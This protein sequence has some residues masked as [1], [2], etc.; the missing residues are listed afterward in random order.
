MKKLAPILLSS[1]LI[2]A[3]CEDSPPEGPALE[4]T[5]VAAPAFENHDPSVAYVGREA[6][7]DCHLAIYNSYA[8]TGMGRS[9]RPLNAETTVGE[10]EGS[11]EFS[12][13]GMTYRVF[14]RDGKY[15]MQEFVKRS[16]NAQL[17]ME[18][19]ELIWV[20][21]SNNHNRA[22][23]I[24]RDGK[25]FQA[26]A[27][28]YPQGD[29]W[30][31]CPGY[32][33]AN[34]HFTRETTQSC[35]FCHNGV[36][37]AVEGRRNIFERPYPH[38]IGCERCHGPGEKHVE[39]WN[40][41]E[42]FGKRDD[43]TIVNPALLPGPERQEVCF[44]CHLGDANQTER[45]IRHDRPMTSFRPG[46]R[47]SDIFVPFRFAVQTEFDFGLSSQADRMMLSACYTESGGRLECLT[48]HD[49]HVPVVEQPEGYVA[50]ACQTCHDVQDC[51]EEHGMREAAGNDCV[52]CHMRR[53]EPDDQRFTEFT[54]HWIRRDISIDTP[55]HRESVEIE[56]IFP[57][58]YATL[59]TG[60]QAY[61]RA[62]ALTQM[63]DSS[64]LRKRAEMN[65]EASKLYAGAIERGYDTADSRYY[66]GKL[67]LTERSFEEAAEQFEAVLRH[68]PD[69]R[70]AL[71][72]LGQYHQANGD[73][74]RAV[75]MFDRIL[76][77]APDTAMAL[78]ERGRVL[79][80]SGDAVAA[81]EHYREALSQEPWNVTYHVNVGMS[82]AANGRMHEAA[83]LAR[84]AARLDPDRPDVWEFNANVLREIGDEQGA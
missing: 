68:D 28:W 63:T 18:E 10:F 53:A 72:A 45:I 4:P 84:S 59:T 58:R 5:A 66:Y 43:P 57:E 54:D 48:C 38:G 55:D 19:H 64:P 34:E 6:C 14:E 60:Q 26:P 25:L 9:F 80:E 41:G 20:V 71:F 77:N 11:P 51:G 39:R 3:G 83:E 7:R 44:Q 67:L 24:E 82:L 15:F 16:S 81:L 33:L 73:R 32:E 35:M 37:R 2:L 79:F 30:A 74:D 29:R 75:E 61:Y 21:G 47:I 22:Y 42:G 65:A 62:R 52:P 27:C 78:A 23:L 46:Q 49:P 13:N 69:H 40:S 76:T 31:L 56:P 8:R 36:M 1:V 70:D 12:E 50:R 17:A